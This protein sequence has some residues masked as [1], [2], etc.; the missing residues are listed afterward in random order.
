MK[1]KLTSFMYGPYFLPTWHCRPFLPPRSELISPCARIMSRQ[2]CPHASREEAPDCDIRLDKKDPVVRE[3]ELTFLWPVRLPFFGRVLP[4][5][6]RRPNL[7]LFALP[8]D[9]Q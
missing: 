2:N 6:R 9:R 4:S 5:A 3:K 1:I 7:N 8:T